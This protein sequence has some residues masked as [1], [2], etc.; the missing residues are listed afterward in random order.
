LYNGISYKKAGNNEKVITEMGH[1]HM[2]SWLCMYYHKIVKSTALKVTFRTNN[3]IRYILRTIP[4]SK[5][6]EN[7]ELTDLDV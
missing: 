7:K 5:E 1:I 2:L 3:L 6:Y 4:V